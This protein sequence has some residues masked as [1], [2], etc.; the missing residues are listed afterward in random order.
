MIQDRPWRRQARRDTR[1]SSKQIFLNRF[2]YSRS[3]PTLLFPHLH[4]FSA[5]SSRSLC[6]LRDRMGIFQISP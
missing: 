2:F 6:C 5:A 3:S 1:N 4:E